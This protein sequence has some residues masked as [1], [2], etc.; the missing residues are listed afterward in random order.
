MSVMT[1]QSWC[2]PTMLVRDDTSQPVTD[3]ELAALRAAA[4]CGRSLPLP[5][6]HLCE[7]GEVFTQRY[8]R[9]AP[10]ALC[11]AAITGPGCDEPE[12]PDD[13]CPGCG[14]CLRYC[15]DCA[16]EALRWTSS[17]PDPERRGSP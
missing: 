13:D 3:D 15:P 6:V 2:Y 12:A 7:L 17:T 14:D 8:W 11:G 4:R 10:T 5:P 1:E 16:R 9:R